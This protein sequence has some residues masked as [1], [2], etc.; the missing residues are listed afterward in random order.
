MAFVDLAKNKLVLKVVLAGPPQVG[1]TERLMQA[2]SAGSSHRYGSKLSPETLVAF[3]PLAAEGSARPVELEIYEWHNQE[4][5][6][7]RGKAIF[8]G[9]DGVIYLADA[10]QDRHV[11]TVG[12]FTYLVEQAGKTRLAR[13]PGLL[14]LGRLDEGLLRL[15][16]FEKVLVGP[17]WNERLELRLEERDRFLEALRLFGEVMLARVL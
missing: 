14:L 2:A 9:L 7:V 12:Q 11:D 1:K 16:S 6:D 3:F 17:A 8:T 10:R 4:R 15:S 5:V 13:L